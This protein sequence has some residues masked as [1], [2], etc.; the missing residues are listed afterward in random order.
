MM[1]VLVRSAVA[2]AI[3]LSPAGIVAQALKDAI[4]VD[5]EAMEGVA[6]AFRAGSPLRGLHPELYDVKNG[7]SRV[8]LRYKLPG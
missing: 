6:A 5:A 4:V 1:A 8:S 7:W 2:V 3:A